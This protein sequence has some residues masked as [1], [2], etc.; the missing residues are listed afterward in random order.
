MMK[1]LDRDVMLP[2]LAMTL[3]ARSPRP[4]RGRAYEAIV[5]VGGGGGLAVPLINQ[6]VRFPTFPGKGTGLME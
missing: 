4:K 3:E 1:Y 6:P 2:E 5:T